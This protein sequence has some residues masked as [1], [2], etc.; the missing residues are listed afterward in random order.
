MSYAA[1][2]RRPPTTLTDDEVRR[3]LQVTGK[4]ADGFRDHVILSLALGAA[5]REFEIVAL[6]VGDI[7][8][9]DGG[10]RKVLLL[11]TFKGSTGKPGEKPQRV[12]LPESTYYKLEKFARVNE[13]R[14]F[15]RTTQ[16]FWSRKGNRLS[17]RAVRGMFARWQRLAGFGELH[18]FHRLRHTAITMFYRRTKDI[19]LT[20]KFARHAHIDTT[21][22]YEHAPDE[23]LARAVRDLPV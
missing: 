3:L 5:L 10:I 2:T 9:T 17:V 16:L 4:S 14:S 18:N 11:R 7:L 15:Y 12:H 13:L 1:R 19:R 23:E 8:T 20:Q 21:M 22:V 6:D